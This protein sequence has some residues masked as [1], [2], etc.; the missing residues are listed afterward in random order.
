MNKKT[1]DE[2]LEVL[3]WI[4]RSAHMSGPVGTTVYFIGDKSMA[5]AKAI[6]KKARSGKVPGVL[7]PSFEA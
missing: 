7:H 1:Q 4:T 5:R 2:M 6:V 3:D